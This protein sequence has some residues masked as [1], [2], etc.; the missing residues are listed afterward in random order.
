[1]LNTLVLARMMKLGLFNRDEAFQV[2]GAGVFAGPDR[3]MFYYGISLGGIMGTWFAALTPDI[4]RFGVDVPAINFSCLLQRSTQFGQFETLLRTSGLT[5]PMQTILGLQL[6]HEIW[7][8]GEPAG[9]ARHIISEPLPGSGKPKRILMTPA[10]LDKQV[11]NQCT[12]IMAR[13]LQIA[14]LVPGSI[15][16]E[17]VRI[18]DVEGP[19]DSAYVMYDTGSF[20]L[21]NEAHQPFI[22]P[23]A[24]LIPSPKCDPHGARPGIPAGIV[25][26]FEF[27]QPGGR[28]EN[29]CDGDCD[30]G[31]PFEIGLGDNPMPCDP[32]Q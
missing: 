19:L 2:D 13:T 8:S 10:W 15:Q 6:Q 28:I 12:E 9:Y 18:P 14:N 11:S 4:E 17:L 1:M 31:V 24:N 29:M 20:D 22:P 26:L 16:R 30:A 25:Q 3:E 5:D 21:F 23:L 27:L 32:L 7:V